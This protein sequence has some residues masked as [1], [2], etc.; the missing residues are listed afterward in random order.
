MDMNNGSWFSQ[1]NSVLTAWEN[2]AN[3]PGTEQT[4]SLNQVQ[5]CT[6]SYMLDKGRAIKMPL[7][8]GQQQVSLEQAQDLLKSILQGVES[9][10]VP[11][12]VQYI[13]S[14]MVQQLQLSDQW[15]SENPS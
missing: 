8:S 12:A 11:T 1:L 9:N 10:S 13:V 6:Y 15:A 5:V 14:N 3:T 7:D 4:Q 2:G